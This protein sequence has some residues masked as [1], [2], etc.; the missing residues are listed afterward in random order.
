[1]RMNSRILDYFEE[2]FPNPV[3]ELNYSKDY[4]LLIAIMLSAQTTDKRV[5]VV[6][7]ELFSKFDSVEKLSNAS[8]DD[9]KAIIR[10]L[11]NFTKK[12]E[13]VIDIAKKINEW[14]FVPDDRSLLES[15]PMVGR[16]TVNVF[17]SEYYKIPN[18]AVDTHVER[19]SKRL[20]FVDWDASVLEVESSLKKIVPRD[21]WC[22]THL[23]MVHFGRYYCTSRNPKCDTC[24]ISDLCKIKK[25]VLAHFL[26]DFFIA[27]IIVLIPNINVVA[28][29]I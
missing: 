21:M 10:S 4:E 28:D 17:L 6:T 20:G 3:C 12:S 25:W 22:D 23:R 27:N 8:S 16:K 13:A 2:L 11:G 19:V 15:L 24:K 18:I 1:M 7:K 26:F 14:G 29:N 5:N 9:V